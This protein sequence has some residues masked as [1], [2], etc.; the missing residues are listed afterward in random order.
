MDFYATRINLSLIGTTVLIAV[1]PIS[2]NKDVFE[3]IY[4]DL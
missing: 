4:S 1:V 2:I 3:P